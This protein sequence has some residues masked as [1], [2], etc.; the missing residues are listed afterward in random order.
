M[1]ATLL[2]LTQH[3]QLEGDTAHVLTMQPVLIW[4]NS[5][6]LPGTKSKSVL[7]EKDAVMANAVCQCDWALFL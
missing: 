6:V 3:N 7:K 2:Q 5:Q 4:S 1:S